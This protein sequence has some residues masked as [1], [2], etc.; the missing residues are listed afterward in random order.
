MDYPVKENWRFF[1]DKDAKIFFVENFPCLQKIVEEEIGDF[2]C[3]D[4]LYS[5]YSE[6]CHV[7]SVAWFG[8]IPRLLFAQ[9]Q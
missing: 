9:L 1:I 2:C 5:L 4:F 8:G 3:L 6:R 7:Q